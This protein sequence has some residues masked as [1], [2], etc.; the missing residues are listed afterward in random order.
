MCNQSLHCSATA[1]SK[2]V[3]RAMLAAVMPALLVAGRLLR[4]NSG[5][6][7]ALV[8]LHVAAVGSSTLAL[9]W[10]QGALFVTF[11]AALS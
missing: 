9:R 4:C 8:A 1:C 3:Y 5:H 7:N 6:K 11:F 2:R 10:A